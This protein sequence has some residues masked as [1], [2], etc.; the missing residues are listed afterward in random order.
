[1]FSE[2]YNLEWSLGMITEF[3]FGCSFAFSLT[4][5]NSNIVHESG[6][7]SSSNCQG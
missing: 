5:M 4:Q 3:I 7:H 1:M 2:I 6:K